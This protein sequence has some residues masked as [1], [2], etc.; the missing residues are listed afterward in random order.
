[1]K[2]SGI[3]LMGILMVLVVLFFEEFIFRGLIFGVM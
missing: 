2:K 3:V 1:M